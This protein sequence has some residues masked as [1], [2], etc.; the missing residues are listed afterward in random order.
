MRFVND[1]ILNGSTISIDTVSEVLD[2]STISC[3]IVF[4][5]STKNKA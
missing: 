1:L 2:I 4:E 3:N 5:F